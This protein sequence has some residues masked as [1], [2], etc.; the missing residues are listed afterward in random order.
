MF[1][2]FTSKKFSEMVRYWTL[3]IS[4]TVMLSTLPGCPSWLL[5]IFP[6][7]LTFPDYVCSVA[8]SGSTQCIKG[9]ELLGRIENK[10]VEQKVSKKLEDE[11]MPQRLFE[12]NRDKGIVVQCGENGSMLA[13]KEQEGV[14]KD[15]YRL[16]S[17]NANRIIAGLLDPRHDSATSKI[18]AFDKKHPGYAGLVDKNSTKITKLL[19]EWEHSKV[20]TGLGPVMVPGNP[21]SRNIQTAFAGG[22]VI[23]GKELLKAIGGEAV[24]EGVKEGIKSIFF[25]DSKEEKGTVTKK[26]RVDMGWHDNGDGTR[27]HKEYTAE[28]GDTKVDDDTDTKTKTATTV[29]EVYAEDNSG[30]LRLVATVTETTTTDTSTT[31]KDGKTTVVTTTKTETKDSREENVTVTENS[32]VEVYDDK[33]NLV[34]KQEGKETKVTKPKGANVL[35]AEGG[36][37]TAEKVAWWWKRFKEQCD[38]S[39]WGF[40]E[41]RKY[42]A[43]QHGC[44]D[45]AVLVIAPGGD[46]GCGAKITNDKDWA[47]SAEAYCKKLGG[48]MSFKNGKTYC[49]VMLERSKMGNVTQEAFKSICADPAAVLEKGACLANIE[50]PFMPPPGKTA[51][52]KPPTHGPGDLGKTPGPKPPTHGL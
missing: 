33:G 30:N 2:R 47:K 4:A 45:P 18:T 49:D 27:T 14:K 29:K 5:K 6:P 16:C 50:L 15:A 35:C 8:D 21:E 7:R 39:D 43:G 24:V 17:D 20:A 1:K 46:F 13:G 41:C 40:Y 52:P 31:T 25:S 34:S 23:F 36:C 28:T 44:P 22:A 26:T 48:A 32:S 12:N 10:E 3:F 11:I 42:I 9:T 37:S 19:G 38:K 51:D